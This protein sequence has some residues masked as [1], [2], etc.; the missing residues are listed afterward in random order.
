VNSDF[1][2]KDQIQSRVPSKEFSKNQPKI[3]LFSPNFQLIF[4]PAG[5]HAAAGA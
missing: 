2:G 4:L 3:D 1:S 5:A